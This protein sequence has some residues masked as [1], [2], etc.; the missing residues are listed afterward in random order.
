M[1]H[2]CTDITT[3]DSI[4]EPSDAFDCPPEA[5][6]TALP[7]L[8]QT[9]YLTIKDYDRESD[10]YD[11]GIP[12]NEVR[13]GFTR[14]LLP[15]YIGI[16]GP[17]VQ[18][19]FALKF[20]QALKKKDI[21][22]AMQEMKAYFAGLPYV[23]GFQKKLAE[24]KNYEG[25]YEW[26]LYLIFSMLNV[27]VRTQVKCAGGRADMVVEMPDTTWVFELKVNGTAQEAL[28]QINSKHYALPYH[29]EDRNVVKV[30]VAFERETMTVWEYVVE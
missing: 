12:N 24:V 10:M 19:G 22:T 13:V 28:D 15:T 3:M 20:W 11:L 8:Y 27:Y 2:F 29:T 16:D 9:G 21:D 17:N 26:S 4:S 6:D 23:E 1:Q 25:F 30:G 5:L 18:K 14:G 7:L